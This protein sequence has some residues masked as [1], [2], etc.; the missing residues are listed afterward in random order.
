MVVVSLGAACGKATQK[1]AAPAQAQPVVKPDPWSA[2]S[3]SAVGPTAYLGNSRLGIRIGHTGLG[4]S[5]DGTL[6]PAFLMSNNSLLRVP[7]PAAMQIWING[8]PLMPSGPDTFESV[9]DFRTGKLRSKMVS[10]GVT[11]AV[12]T[13]VGADAPIVSQRV[14]FEASSPKSV[15]IW[16]GVPTGLANPVE[17][18]SGDWSEFSYSCPTT[19]VS[20]GEVRSLSPPADVIVTFR[21][22]LS[23][24]LTGAW[25]ASRE[26]PKKGQD[27]RG[28]LFE[29]GIPSGTSTF[30]TTSGIGSGPPRWLDENLAESSEV[31][32]D[33]W[34]T[35]I[36]IEGPVEDQQA[37]RSLLF[38]LYMSPTSKMPPMALSSEKYQGHRFWDAEAWMLPV[39]SLIRP[40][41]AKAATEWRL[42]VTDVDARVPWEAGSIGEDLTPPAFR[43]AI[44]VAG[45]VSWWL[46]RA[47]A[48]GLTEESAAYPVLRSVAEFYRDRAVERSGSL[49]ILGVTSPDEGRLRNNDLVTNLLAIRAGFALS[50]DHRSYLGALTTDLARVR[51]PLDSKGIP[52]TFDDDPIRGY[53]Q[54]AAL[55]ALYPIEWPFSRDTQEAFFDRYKTRTSLSGPAMSDSIHA[56]IAARLGRKSEA[57]AIWQ[58]SWRPF[59]R[60]EFMLFSER[61]ATNDV[62]FATGAAGCLQS[63]IYGFLGVHIEKNGGESPPASK[64]LLNGY[65]LAVRPNLP[66]AWKSITFKNVRL[67]GEVITIRA[68]H[69]GAEILPGGE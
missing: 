21:S 31:W 25:R 46:E 28:Y 2:I 48:M 68:T 23:E 45:W 15:Q 20:A 18:N 67:L 53:Q 24:N 52:L 38:Y 64:P 9:L 26:S 34:Q 19:R 58:D 12:E 61:R 49:H 16:I 42:S 14:T 51:I 11:V 22:R 47:V 5:P 59:V 55:L 66:P 3:N 36:E 50:P 40:A 60:P 10:Q 4:T 33:R 54:A 57:Y 35:D 6:L 8:Q 41:A 56:V 63:V 30:E 13:L 44:H 17:S 69:D 62:Y 27:G 7:H 43:E 32:S 37:I 29:G 39:Y 65:R 1:D